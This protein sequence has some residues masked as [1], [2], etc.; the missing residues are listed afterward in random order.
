MQHPLLKKMVPGFSLIEI[1]IVLVIVGILMGSVFKGKNLLDQ[2]KVNATVTEFLQI[3]AA[4]SSYGK[5]AELFASPENIWKKL[6]EV[7]LWAQPQAPTSRLGGVFS[8]FE[9]G[10]TYYLRLSSG[11]SSGTAFLTGAQVK[12]LSLKLQESNGDTVI[13]RDSSNGILKSEPQKD[14]TYSIEMALTS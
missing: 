5:E 9:S 13:I 14:G 11:G 12:A 1:S 10:G 7:G 2:A 3:Q 4:V 8:V 6:A